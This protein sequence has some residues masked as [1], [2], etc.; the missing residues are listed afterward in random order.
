MAHDISSQDPATAISYWLAISP[1]GLIRPPLD[2]SATADVAIVGAGFTGLWTAL[3]LTDTDPS[4]QVVVLEQETV[5]FGASGRNGGFCQASLTHGLANGI[6]HFPDELALLERQGIA[7][8]AALVA[9]TREHG[10]DCDLEETGGLAVADQPHQVEEFRAWVD[11][12]AEYG[13]ELVFLDREAIQAEVH[14]P[15]WQAGL[16]QPPGRDVVLDPAKLVRGLARVCEERGIAILEHTRVRAVERRAGGVRIATEG[17]ATVE[18]DHVVVATSAY[19]GWLR[20]LET[21]FVPVYDYVLV[22]D[23]MTPE[24]RASIG[25]Q[26]RQGMSD[27]NNQFHYFRLTADDRILWGGYDAVYYRNN[28]VGPQFDRR[29]ATFEKLEGQFR[30]AFPQLTDLRFPYRWGGAIDTTSRFTV[31][32]G[33]ALGGR[34]TYAIGYTG[35]G[36]GASRWAA[37]VVRDFILRPDS[38][39]LR[40]RFVRSR[41][42]PFPPEP[43]RWLAVEAVRRELDRADRNEGRRGILLR[44]LDALGIGFDS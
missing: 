5:G 41:P 27:A 12:A 21:H 1:A 44:T 37:G 14:S 18:A 2:G 38:D 35:L 24:Q 23:P 3:A 10:I 33:Q 39:L 36:V 4:L 9:F 26:R 29:P 40:L 6:R 15:L 13:E 34:L 20:R 32:F 11:E 30:R 22:S 28:G 25:W 19:S 42:F 7:N 31:T 16:Y 17:G 43:L 8:L